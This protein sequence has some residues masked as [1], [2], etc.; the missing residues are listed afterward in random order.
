MKKNT[1]IITALILLIISTLA[2]VGCG[3]TGICDGCNQQ[4]SLYKYVRD[5]GVVKWYCDDCM[6]MEKLFGN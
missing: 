4:E 2:I 1:K 6:R 3:K 5:N